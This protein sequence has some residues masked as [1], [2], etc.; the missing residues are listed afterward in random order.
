MRPQT[1]FPEFKKT[2]TRTIN[3]SENSHNLSGL[4]FDPSILALKADG[5]GIW[6]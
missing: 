5:A 3:A 1:T 6:V 4:K 2:Q